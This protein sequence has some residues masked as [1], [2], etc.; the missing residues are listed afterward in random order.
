MLLHDKEVLVVF[1]VIAACIYVVGAV[2]FYL[3]LAPYIQ[4]PDE[5]STTKTWLVALSTVL[6]PLAL[7]L[8][9]LYRFIA[10]ILILIKFYR[11]FLREQLK[12]LLGIE[13]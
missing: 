2:K 9:G 1:A 10:G 7:L 13:D 3:P 11:G 4:G 5:W 12:P 8:I 6:W